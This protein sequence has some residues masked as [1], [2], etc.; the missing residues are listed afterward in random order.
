[1]SEFTDKFETYMLEAYEIDEYYN[2][3]RLSLKELVSV[4][5]SDLLVENQDITNKVKYLIPK[6]E[7]IAEIKDNNT[8]FIETESLFNYTNADALVYL[9]IVL[10]SFL[11]NDPDKTYV[12]IYSHSKNFTY[13]TGVYEDSDLFDMVNPK[14]Q[15]FFRLKR[16][17][18]GVSK[19]VSSFWGENKIIKNAA[20]I[21]FV[22]NSNN[23]ISVFINKY[24]ETFVF[25][26]LKENVKVSNFIGMLL[27]D[28][29]NLI[30]AINRHIIKQTGN[31]TL[32]I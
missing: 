32:I 5:N 20:K 1:M 30:E 17:D 4:F 12:D 27:A 2:S 3:I 26:G 25:R 24:T 8:L 6:L 16:P 10:T 21:M 15:F 22:P 7:K 23:D 13:E 29:Q 14:F 19:I 11:K 18:F 31:D 28:N 9:G